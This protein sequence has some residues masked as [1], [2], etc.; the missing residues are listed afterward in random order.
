M[1]NV[2]YRDTVSL[3]VSPKL[4][5]GFHFNVSKNVRT[6]PS[7]RCENPTNSICQ[8]CCLQKEC[9]CVEGYFSVVGYNAGHFAEFCFLYYILYNIQKV[10]V[11]A[12]MRACFTFV[13]CTFSACLLYATNVGKNS[14]IRST[15]LLKSHRLHAK[16]VFTLSPYIINN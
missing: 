3:R 8:Y 6:S 16:R 1:S 14:K 4:I 15:E 12:C 9:G 5:G 7:A 13:L 11:C 10:C 2:V